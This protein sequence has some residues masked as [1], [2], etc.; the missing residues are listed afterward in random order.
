MLL[1]E[2]GNIEYTS[3]RLDNSKKEQKAEAF[4]RIS[5]RGQ[6]P[7]LQDGALCI[8]ESSAILAYID[9]T[10]LEDRYL[11]ASGRTVAIIQ[12]IIATVCGNVEPV[13]Q[14]V[15][16]PIFRN[17]TASAVEQIQEGLKKTD[18]ELRLLEDSLNQRSWLTGDELTAA[19]IHLLPSIERL[20]R[21]TARENAAAIDVPDFYNTYPS[22]GAW[23]NRFRALPAYDK[24]YPPHWRM[25]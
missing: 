6:V 22:L 11:G 20:L 15:V 4:L 14:Q 1:L 24:C 3:H 17:K 7:V 10:Y 13:I 23:L 8:R 5:P 16:Q 12:E 21:A 25:P 19:D 18:K 9:K 2:I